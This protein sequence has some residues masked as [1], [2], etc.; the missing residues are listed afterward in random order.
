MYLGIDLQT[1]LIYESSGEPSQPVLPFP[2]VTQA[3][4]IEKPEDWNSLPG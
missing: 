2:T 1:G 3:K 4:V